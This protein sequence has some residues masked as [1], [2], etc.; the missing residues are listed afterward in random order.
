MEDEEGSGDEEVSAGEG[1]LE[2]EVV[3]E[4]GCGETAEEADVIGFA[5]DSVFS[6]EVRDEEH[7]E[8]DGEGACGA[9]V[10]A[11]AEED[12]G[13]D[14]GGVEGGDGVLDGRAGGGERV[15]AEEGS[16]GMGGLD[17]D[18]VSEDPVVAAGAED[19]VEEAE[20]PE[21]REPFTAF[22]GVGAAVEG[23]E[24]AEEGDAAEE[25]EDGGGL[26][27]AGAGGGGG[28]GGHVR[29]GWRR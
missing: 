25:E 13:E 23:G 9:V 17:D 24:G 28:T 11:E 26:E 5:E 4:E 16:E 22:G 6:V 2:P 21:T 18:H 15:A 14:G 1:R 20:V 7:E 12:A 29:V 10:V 27:R 3:D 8:R 19:H